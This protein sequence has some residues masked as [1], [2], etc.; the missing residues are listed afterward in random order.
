[1]TALRQTGANAF[2][3]FYFSYLAI[4]N[5]ELGRYD[6][7]DRL[8]EDVMRDVET[9]KQPGGPLKRSGLYASGLRS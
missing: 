9:T 3:S 4:A 7:A 1:M 6:E 8:I 2:S 5:A